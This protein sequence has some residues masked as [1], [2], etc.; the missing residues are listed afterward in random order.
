MLHR[1]PG[2]T[3][4]LCPS[5]DPGWSPRMSPGRS[6]SPLEVE[7]EEEV[8]VEVGV[9]VVVD[10]LDMVEALCPVEVA[11]EAV[12][13]MVEGVLEALLTTGKTTLRTMI[14]LWRTGRWLL[15]KVSI[16]SM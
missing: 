13:L 8:E 16:L 9:V 14:M 11:T 5:R 1:F 3:V 15:M 10:L 6:V 7:E 4:S 12:A 2:D